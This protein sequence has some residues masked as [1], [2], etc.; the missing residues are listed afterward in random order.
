MITK[1]SVWDVSKRILL[2][3]DF[4]NQDQV[5]KYRDAIK[6]LDLNINDCE[7]LFFTNKE[8][9]G[10]TKELA[11]VNY[12]SSKDL[13]FFGKI[14][15]EAFLKLMKRRFDLMIVIGEIDKRFLKKIER[16]K[17]EFGV[18]VNSQISF[19]NINLKM[20]SKDPLELVNFTKKT[21][22]KIQ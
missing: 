5:L 18:G 12:L 13:G 17:F 2:V 4:Y 8:N 3:T 19:I 6:S 11:S 14:K 9:N 16:F 21:L 15:N 1:G 20:N 10:M 7:L 22:Q